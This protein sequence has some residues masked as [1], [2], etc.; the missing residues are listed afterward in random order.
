[1]ANGRRSSNAIRDLVIDG[2][3]V[4]DPT[5]V[6]EGIFRSFKNHFKRADMVYPKIG[7][8]GLASIS[9]EAKSSLEDHFS[10]DKV[11]RALCNC[12]GNKALGLE[13]FNM[14]FVKAH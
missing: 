8:L 3:K 1:M 7:Y 4:L 11:W 5:L 10:S 13:G 12:D 2:M 6:R 14:N 9:E